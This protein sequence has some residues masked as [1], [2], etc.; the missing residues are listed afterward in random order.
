MDGVRGMVVSAPRFVLSAWLLYEESMER[1]RGDGLGLWAKMESPDFPSSESLR[2]QSR[3]CVCITVRGSDGHWRRGKSKRCKA[4]ASA[5]KAERA[6]KQFVLLD[7]WGFSTIALPRYK[8]LQA[9]VVLYARGVALERAYNKALREARHKQVKSAK[10]ALR[11]LVEGT[12]L[13][14]PMQRR[15]RREDER[16]QKSLRELARGDLAYRKKQWKVAHDAYRSYRQLSPQAWNR[17]Q[18]AQRRDGGCRGWS[19]NGPN[20]IAQGGGGAG[21]EIRDDR[22]RRQTGGGLWAAPR[23]EACAP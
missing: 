7:T 16:L 11:V 18:I 6:W 20:G 12:T 15:F 17:R 23:N 21:C 3:V 4:Q 22:K 5:E 2:Q 10:E 1:T 9:G 14:E 19:K 13:Q 8:R